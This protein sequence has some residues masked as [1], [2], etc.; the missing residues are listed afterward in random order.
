MK[1]GNDKA[2]KKLYQELGRSIFKALF[3]FKK[4]YLYISS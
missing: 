1:T 2:I 3:S 4:E